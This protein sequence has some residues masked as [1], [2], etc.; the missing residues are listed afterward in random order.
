MDAKKHIKLLEEKIDELQE[1]LDALQKDRDDTFAQLQR[2]GADY[3]N[4]QRRAPKQI[5][6]SIAYEKK[7]IIKSLLPS[8]D[9]FEHALAGAE[10]AQDTESV[11]KGVR[12]IFE[13]MLDALKTHGVRQIEARNQ[14]FDPMLHQAMLQRN[15]EDKPDGIVLEEFQKGYMINDDVLRPTKVIVNKSAMKA[16]EAEAPTEK[17]GE[18]TVEEINEPGGDEQPPQE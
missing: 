5:A 2:I 15:E 6:D 11:V 8:L 3:A 18:N 14:P 12:L 4:Y 10:T 17:T 16:P 7:A 9:N 13:H 1:K